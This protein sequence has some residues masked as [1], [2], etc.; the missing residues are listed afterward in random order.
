[1]RYSP[2]PVRHRSLFLTFKSNI[3]RFLLHVMEDEFDLRLYNSYSEW[4]IFPDR[5]TSTLAFQIQ[6]WY[7]QFVILSLVFLVIYMEVWMRG[8]V[9]SLFMLTR[10]PPCSSTCP[11]RGEKTYSA[12]EYNFSILAH[13]KGCQIQCHITISFERERETKCAFV[14]QDNKT[15]QS[16][17]GISNMRKT[18]WMH[19]HNALL[20]S[21][22]LNQTA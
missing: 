6:P 11:V 22:L 13:T 3:F 12:M 10:S 15:Q 17:D 4:I 7:Y 20:Q 5:E 8:D 21:A 14:I 1:M 9:W 19:I 18:E 2:S 16:S